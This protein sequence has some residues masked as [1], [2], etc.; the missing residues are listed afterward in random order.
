MLTR[1]ERK[2]IEKSERAETKPNEKPGLFEVSFADLWRTAQ[3]RRSAYIG[4][5]IA[6]IFRQSRPRTKSSDD[7]RAVPPLRHINSP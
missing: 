4:L 2:S 3:H 5:W 6:Q 1:T 7:I